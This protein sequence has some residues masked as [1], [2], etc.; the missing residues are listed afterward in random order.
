MASGQPKQFLSIRGRTLLEWSVSALLD[1]PL[2]EGC[3]VALPAADVDHPDGLS[4][5]GFLRDPRVRCC[6]GGSSRAASVLAGLAA[7]PAA[8]N[9]WVL[10]H[11]A[12]RPCLLAGDLERLINAVT[13][14]GVGGILARPVTDTLKRADATGRV[15]A[16]VE[17]SELWSAQTPQ[18]F[19]RGELR[20][21]LEQAAERGAT[22]TD[23]SSAME[24]AGH[25]VQLVEGSVANLKVTYPAD[26][27]LAAFWLEQLHGESPVMSTTIDSCE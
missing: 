6:A 18:M 7:V 2:I 26:I 25:P 1:S 17:R 27:A 16:T 10:V 12:A 19:R 22:V 5:E 8:E 24:L 3:V 20:A 13:T 14:V 23:E 15:S 21:A 11:D 9:D 4:G